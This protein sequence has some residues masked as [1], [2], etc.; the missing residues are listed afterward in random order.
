MTQGP[1]WI[2][3]GVLGEAF[4]PAANLL[5]QLE[6]LSG[7]SF[8]LQLEDGTGCELQL[9]TSTQLRWRRTSGEQSHL[10]FDDVTAAYRATEIRP[11]IVLLSFLTANGSASAITVV[12]DRGRGIATVVLGQLPSRSEAAETLLQRIERGAEL[13]SVR[14]TLLAGAIDAPFDSTTPRHEETRELIGKRIEY[15][16]SPTERY[17]HVYLNEGLYCWHC[18][19]GSEKGLA[20]ADRCHYRKIAPNLYLFVWRE[21]IVPTLGIVLV[22]LTQLRTTGHILGYKGFDFGAVT[23]FPVGARARIVNVT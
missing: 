1:E 16:Y 6:N 18:L 10:Q 15:T 19:A 12:L 4:E 21:K 9:L 11:G 5:P 3:V 20:D 13:T 22:D 2:S 7:S 17:E 8:T 23:S 14:A